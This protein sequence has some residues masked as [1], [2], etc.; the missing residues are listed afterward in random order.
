M[1]EKAQTEKRAQL[2][3]ATMALQELRNEQT[4]LI[5]NRQK[6][7][8][9][10]QENEL[11]DAEFKLLSNTARV[12]KMI[13]PVL[14]P[15]DKLEATANVEKRLE[16]IRDEVKRI[17]VRLEQ[18]AKEQQAKSTDA[19]KLQMELQGVSQA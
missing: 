7:E 8:S 18:L 1:S 17:E 5:E 13:G 12:Y 10:L 3:K 19:Y 11:V 4:T 14:V 6:L 16:Y 9:Q 15:Q 2:E